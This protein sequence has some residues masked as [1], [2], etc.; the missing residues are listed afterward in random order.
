MS[1]SPAPF[2]AN[3]PL[4]NLANRFRSHEYAGVMQRINSASPFEERYGFSR[5][6]RT[7]DLIRVAGTAPITQDGSETPPSAFDQMLLCGTIALSA[8]AELGGTADGVVRT[9]MYITDASESDEVGR[10]HRE[11]FGSAAPPAT[12]VVVAGLLDPAWKVE[13]EVEAIVG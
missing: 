10:A 5:A 1:P 8:I 4:G 2:V 7:G 6:I 13:I 9:R 3:T 11:L 12:M